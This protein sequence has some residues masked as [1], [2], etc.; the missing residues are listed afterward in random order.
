MPGVAAGGGVEEVRQVQPVEPGDEQHGG[1]HRIGEEPGQAAVQRRQQPLPQARRIVTAGRGQRPQGQGDRGAQHQ[2]DRDQ[3]RQAHVDHHVHAEH[4][5]HVA[6]DTRRRG[7]QQ[8]QAA[9]QPGESTARRPFVAAA[10]QPQQRRHIQCGEDDGRGS[11][12]QVEAPIEQDACHRG[13]PVEVISDF[14]FGN[15]RQPGRR[16]WRRGTAQP[17]GDAEREAENGGL[18]QRQPQQRATRAGRTGICL[19]RNHTHASLAPAEPA[20]HAQR[21]ELG[22]H[23]PAIVGAQQV[24]RLHAHQRVHQPAQRHRHPAPQRDHRETPGGQP[25]VTTAPQG[26]G[27]QGQQATGPQAGGDKVDQQAIGCQ[28]VRTSGRRMTGQARAESASSPTRRPAPASTTSAAPTG[29]P[30]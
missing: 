3:H 18:D 24:G 12:D 6:A 9:E 29:S 30:P 1:H 27:K 10:T 20:Q 28:V 15:R 14:G 2:Q 7:E 25:E 13:W 22:D 5:R 21:D 19:Q 17:D 11:E 16:W 4:R 26:V 23:Q 8:H